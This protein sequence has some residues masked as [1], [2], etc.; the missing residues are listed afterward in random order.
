MRPHIRR[1]VIVLWA[2]VFVVVLGIGARLYLMSGDDMDVVT[3]APPSAAALGGPFT[4]LDHRGATVTDKDF[5]GRWMLIYFGYTFCPDVCPTSLGVMA[6]AMDLLGDRGEAVVPLFISVDPARD[7][8]A[9]LADYV[10][11]FHPRMVGLT[12]TPEQVAATAKAYRVYYARG[13]STGDDGKDYLVDHTSIVYL[14]DPEG[15]FHGHFAGKNIS[16]ET[17]AERI[18]SLL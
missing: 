15:R 11:N 10:T 16:P 6:E 18:G 5:R 14:I 2:V 4:L 17:M 12:G 3:A 9:H 13:E 8:P 7:T 1:L